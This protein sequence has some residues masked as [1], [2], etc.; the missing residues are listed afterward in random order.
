MNE[1]L[2]KYKIEKLLKYKTQAKKYF[3]K[4]K[5][6]QIVHDIDLDI[7][8]SNSWAIDLWIAKFEMLELATS[9]SI[10]MKEISEKY[11]QVDERSGARVFYF[12][13]LMDSFCSDV[14]LDLFIKDYI[15]DEKKRKHIEIV[16]DDKIQE[17]VEM[18][19]ERVAKAKKSHY[20]HE[21]IKSAKFNRNDKIIRD[22]LNQRNEDYSLSDDID[23]LLK[24]KESLKGRGGKGL[25]KY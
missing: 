7:K 12:D 6:M 5:A 14:F 16:P 23:Q 2:L 20:I 15:D 21:A 24:N 1:E 9:E 18:Y 11:C 19:T 4:E 22:A 13:V 3:P 10:S 17:I 25:G 8:S